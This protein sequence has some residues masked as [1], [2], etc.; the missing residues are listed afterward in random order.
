MAKYIVTTKSSVFD[1]YMVE[2]EDGNAAV[3]RVMAHLDGTGNLEGVRVLPHTNADD[4]H[5]HSVEE[6]G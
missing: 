4:E 2:A 6:A 1:H 5:I 3:R